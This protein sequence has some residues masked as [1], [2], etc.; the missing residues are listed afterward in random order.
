MERGN[1][2]RMIRFG[3][4]FSF[5]MLQIA[6]MRIIYPL[7]KNRLS[8]EKREEFLTNLENNWANAT[9]RY[10]E[11]KIE[12]IGKENLIEGTC[13]YVANHQ[14]MLDV[15]LI[16]ANVNNTVA[17]ISKKELG[18][19]P[20]V[21]YWMKEIG[22]VYIDRENGREGLKAILKG[23][24][25]LENGR[26]MLIFPEGTRNRGGLTAEFKKGSLKLATKSN[27][28][29]IP[30]TVDGTYKGLEEPSGD[31]NAKIIIHKPIYTKD[32]LKEE[33]A[34]L[35]ETCKKIIESAL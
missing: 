28:P 32:L 21:S 9:I 5:K 15:P 4:K 2:M 31:L 34:D 11:L 35:A 6:L 19:V 1:W 16:M 3:I 20:V 12:V 13:L 10:S 8:D 18:K 14:S 23:I 25:H 30:I 33:K 27:V 26:S 24:E 17:A 29:V 22:C 7:Y